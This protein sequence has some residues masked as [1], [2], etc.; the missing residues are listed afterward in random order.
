MNINSSE[1]IN[2]YLDWLKKN[3][4][5]LKISD[6]ITEITMPFLDRRNDHIQLY[7]ISSENDKVIISD[8]GYTISELKMS[9]MNIET[10][11]RKELL[12]FN[13]NRYGV[14]YSEKDDS[15]FITSNVSNLPSSQH[16][17]IQAMLDIDD[18]FYTN[19]VNV[20]S[21]FLEEVTDFFDNNDI[22][23]T[24]QV[25]FVGK[26][27]YEHN[28]DFVLQ[29]N[30]NNNERLVKV[31]NTPSKLNIERSIF[32]WNDT[33]DIR[34]DKLSRRSDFIVIMNDSTNNIEDASSAL[35][36]YDITPIGWSDIKNYVPKLA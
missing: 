29:R 12:N 5:Q 22:Y 3:S 13:L 8:Y 6:N 14:K 26:S 25:N 32:S 23:Y 10:P 20:K 16:K 36:S 4:N 7:I 19:S 18:M 33:K 24:E 30:K 11:K 31:L 1:Y 34:G 2:N 27:G 28:Y 21:I 15:L 9:G 35:K 17:L